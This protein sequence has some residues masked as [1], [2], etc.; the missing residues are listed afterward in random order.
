MLRQSYCPRSEEWKY[1]ERD[2]IAKHGGLPDD[3]WPY[4]ADLNKSWQEM[5]PC[6]NEG[7]T[8]RPP[9]NGPT[10]RE[11]VRRGTGP[12]MRPAFPDWP[13]PRGVIPQKPYITSS[14]SS[15]RL[16]GVLL[17]GQ[18]QRRKAAAKT[19]ALF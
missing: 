16:R 14:I 5:L 12:P 7:P 18:E 1:W 11:P 17:A 19:R 10:P 6:E 9:D 8:P 4:V 15:A 13:S 2:L 3:Y